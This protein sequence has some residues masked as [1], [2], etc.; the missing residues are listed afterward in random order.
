MKHPELEWN[1]K[2]KQWFCRRCFKTSDHLTLADAEIELS[3]FDCIATNESEADFS[4]IQ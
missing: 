4:R 1:P 2:T 3:Q